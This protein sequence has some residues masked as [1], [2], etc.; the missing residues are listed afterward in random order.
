MERK[1]FKDTVLGTPQGGIV[2]P[3]LANVYLHQLDVFMR[4]YTDLSPYDRRVGRNKGQ[5]NFVYARYADDFVVLCN[6]TQEQA[7][8]MR[9][10]IHDYLQ[11]DLHLTLSLEKTKVTHINNGFD[12]L[13]FRL[14]RCTSGNGMVTKLAIPNKALE[15]HRGAL[16]AALAPSTCEDSIT[17]KLMALNRIIG[18]WCRHYQ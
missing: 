4:D 7:L 5:A 12:F 15:K 16:R 8:E 9:K 6:G 3:L 2:S 18:G 11:K 17:T 1:L 10:E 14:K 13:G